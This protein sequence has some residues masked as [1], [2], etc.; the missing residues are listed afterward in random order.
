MLE[1]IRGEHTATAQ[2]ALT[3]IQGRG[4]DDSEELFIETVRKL[5]KAGPQHK[6]TKAGKV[7]G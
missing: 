7:K 4:C 5:A 3:S 1:C 2:A 6:P